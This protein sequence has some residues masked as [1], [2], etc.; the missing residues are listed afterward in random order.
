MN[1]LDR[2]KQL[3]KLIEEQ[4]HEGGNALNNANM[5]DVITNLSYMVT[6]INTLLTCGPISISMSILETP[7][8]SNIESVIENIEV[9]NNTDLLVRRVY[10]AL[11]ERS[12]LGKAEIFLNSVKQKSDAKIRKIAYKFLKNNEVP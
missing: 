2:A 12:E 9:L 5:A 6:N 10:T 8:R 11:I 7:N 1:E 3:F 4:A